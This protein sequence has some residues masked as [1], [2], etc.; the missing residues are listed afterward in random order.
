MPK[1]TTKIVLTEKDLKE[2]IS[3][4]YNLD[5][6]TTTITID[7]YKADFRDPRETSYTNIIVE[8]VKKI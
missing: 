2:L 3:K 1:V 7:V 4:E 5:L 8:G 6:S